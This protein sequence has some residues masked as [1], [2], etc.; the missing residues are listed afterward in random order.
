MTNQIQCCLFFSV[1]VT[2]IP[3]SANHMAKNSHHDF[4]LIFELNSSP[5]IGRV[6]FFFF[7][8]LKN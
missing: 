1:H 6:F 2:K 4:L 3:S 7:F 5:W 8:Q